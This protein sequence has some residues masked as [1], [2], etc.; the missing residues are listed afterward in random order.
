MYF[1][2]AKFKNFIIPAVLS[3][4]LLVMFFTSSKTQISPEK[5]MEEG[6][7]V[8]FID[9]MAGK[10]IN[11]KTDYIPARYEIEGLTGECKIRGH[12]NTT[13]VTRELYKRS[14]LLKLNEPQ[15]LLGMESSRKWIL[16][17]NTADKTSLRN[18]YGY[19]LSRKVWNRMKWIPSSRFAA[20][21]LNGKYNGLYAVTEKIE[22]DKFDLPE[23]S[24]LANVNSRMNKE[25]NF[26]TTRG[27]KVSIRM[28]DK[29]ESE[30]K[31]MAD[32]IQNAEDVIF[33]DEFKSN[34]KG[35]QSVI[36]TD[37]FVDWY[38][39]NEFTKNHDAR[40]Q[41]SCYFYYNSQTKKLYMGPVWDMD[42]S[43]GNISYDKC[44]EPEGLWIGKSHWYKR[45]LEDEHFESL[46][47][48]R[49]HETRLLLDSSFSW[50]EEKAKE[51][52]PYVELNDSVWRNIGRRQWP[53]APGWKKRK[54]YKSEVDYMADFLTKR[55]QWIDNAYSAD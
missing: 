41:A 54:T 45:L 4:I 16:M 32:I 43:C 12:G 11:S 55:M 31:S 34:E 50:L 13:W 3:V 24:F 10:K 19:F 6:L 47:K 51:T 33:S 14:Y 46:V 22:F 52:Q 36:D 49:W 1:K 9:T 7:P 40:F 44:Q 42:I 25:W 17:A 21:F 5:C 29:S 26:V 8:L 38:L 48:S 37:S 18:E 53:H 39:I 35:W 15:P 28:K 27:V 20:L 2:S 23:G 30:Y